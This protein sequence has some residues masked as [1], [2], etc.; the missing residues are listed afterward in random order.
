MK[1]ASVLWF[2]YSAAKMFRKLLKYNRGLDVK[3][4]NTGYQC[5]A[6]TT[7]V[8]THNSCGS[9]TALSR[10]CVYPSQAVSTAGE[11]EVGEPG[12]HQS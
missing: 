8:M 12:H 11:V 6:R 9:L 1:T 3:S 5:S 2:K 10:E 4:S 7:R